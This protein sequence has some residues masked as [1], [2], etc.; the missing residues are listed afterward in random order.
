MRKIQNEGSPAKRTAWRWFSKYIRLRDALATTGSPDY[1]KCIT[2]DEVKP[3]DQIEAGH[4]IPGR[5]NGILFDET[6]VFG[7]CKTCNGP[8]GG[9]KQAYRLKMVER[10]GQDWYELKVSARKGAVQ[11]TD[12][13]Y[14]QI[15][16]EYR[17]KY[18]KLKD[19]Y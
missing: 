1:C 11:L 8:N 13:D 10:H 18:N 17:K 4:M 7:Q 12:F 2:C 14:R 15:A 19:S 5:T 6:I 9:E 3:S 16:D